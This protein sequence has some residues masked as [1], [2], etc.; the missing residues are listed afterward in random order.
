MYYNI[1]I[2]FCIYFL[3]SFAIAVYKFLW[4]L[5]VSKRQHIFTLPINWQDGRIGELGSEVLSQMS[6]QTFE[7]LYKSQVSSIALMLGSLPQ[8]KNQR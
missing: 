7:T 5:T 4:Q 3:F 2:L 8:S 1:L 6:Y